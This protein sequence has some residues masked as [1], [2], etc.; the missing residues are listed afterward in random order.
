MS[1]ENQNCFFAHLEIC[2][3]RLDLIGFFLNHLVEVL[4]EE[5]VFHYV[6]D[7]FLYIGLDSFLHH[8]VAGWLGK[9]YLDNWF[10]IVVWDEYFDFFI[11]ELLDLVLSLDS[12]TFRSLPCLLRID[13]A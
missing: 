3:D 2:Q 9:F 6:L 12:A 7:S 11:V 8:G 10:L 4:I 1:F 13:R 5:E